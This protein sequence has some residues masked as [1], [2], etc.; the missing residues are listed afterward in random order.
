M[1]PYALFFVATLGQVVVALFGL[2]LALYLEDVRDR[3]PEDG[4]TFVWMISW[5]ALLPVLGGAFLLW[6]VIGLT[7]QAKELRSDIRAA[8][9]Q[10]D[11]T[12]AIITGRA[13][14]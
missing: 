3:A 13:G 7:D 12:A 4:G 5:K 10:Q 14:Q 2:L 8:V 9:Q 11:K 1:T 6:N